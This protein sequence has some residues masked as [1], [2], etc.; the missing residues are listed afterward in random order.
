MATLQPEQ[1]RHHHRRPRRP[2]QYGPW[3]EWV[4]GEVRDAVV[5]AGVQ[6]LYQ[7]QV[8]AAELAWHGSSVVLATGTAS[9]KSLAYL[10]PILS[11][12]NADHH[13]ERGRATTE[14]PRP[15]A[16]YLAP[17]KALA[18]DQLRSVLD[19][20]IPGV[21]AATHDGDSSRE[22]REWT[23]AHANLGLTNPDMLHHAVLPEHERWR[24]FLSGLELVV[25]DECHHYRGV[26]GAH[27]AQILRRLRRVARHHGSDPVFVLASATVAEPERTATAL[28]GAPVVSAGEDTSSRSAHDIVFMVPGTEERQ[29]GRMVPRPLTTEAA[30]LSSAIAQRSSRGLTFMSSR[31]GVETVAARAREHLRDAAPALEGSVAAYRGGYLPHE[32]RSLER[33]IRSDVISVMAATSALEL[34][35]DITGLDVVVVAGWPGTRSAFWQRAGRAGRGDADAVTML[36]AGENPLD[37]Y[38]VEHPEAVL[39]TPTEA[40]VVDPTN[41]YVL[42]PHLCAAAAELPLTPAEVQGARHQEV[43]ASLEQQRM[44]RRRRTGWYWTGPGRAHSL[45]DI[46]GG[47]DGAVRIVESTTGRLV[48]TV[49]HAA[50]DAAVHAGAVYQHQGETFLVENLDLDEKVA[51][52][53]REDPGFSTVARSVSD[54]AVLHTS[55]SVSW[56]P[57]TLSMGMV[58]VSRQVTSY[59]RRS[60]ETGQI[61]GVS[62]LDLPIRRLRTAACWWT[63]PDG[64]VAATGLHTTQIPGAAHAAEHAGIGM[65]PLVA[66]CDRWDI[67]GVSTALHP[68]TEQLTVLVYDGYPGGAGFAERGHRDAL[69]W[70]EAT[71][72][73]IAA[74]PCDSGCPSCVQSPKCGNGN[75]PLDK[76]GAVTLLDA[77]LAGAPASTSDRPLA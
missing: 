22:E 28:V 10:L 76:R 18:A 66:T 60:V 61:L 45:A 36:V 20:G 70:W 67:G 65:L 51:F 23:R 35:V 71:R 54:V 15:T 42:A 30:R 55:E 31:R 37:R 48:G 69:R 73:A 11:R 4:P 26:F 19:L 33:D 29:D 27:V 12:L 8:R 62:E 74:C 72:S 2:A 44:L 77:L 63:L 1:V 3:P 53:R 25:L 52:V 34:G 5:R 9:G 39:G 14:K 49:D 32:R 46:R 40:T 43:V 50:A 17:T 47:R 6:R 13:R 21:R 75:E 7:H 59:V 64:V 16:L 56:G 38:L 41:P 68:D 58:E 57:A 24:R